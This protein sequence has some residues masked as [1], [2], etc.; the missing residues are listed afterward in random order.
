MTADVDYRYFSLFL[1]RKKKPTSRLASG[2]DYNRS[3]SVPADKIKASTAQKKISEPLLPNLPSSPEIE[4]VFFLILVFKIK[5]FCAF[6]IIIIM[7][8]AFDI[9]FIAIEIFY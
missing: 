6:L 9:Y 5:Y 2:V 1:V 8:V 7:A 4:Y 3:I